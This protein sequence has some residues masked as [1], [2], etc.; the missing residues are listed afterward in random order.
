MALELASRAL[1]A[2]PMWGEDGSVTLAGY[3]IPSAVPNTLTLNFEGG[4]ND[5]ETFSF[6][7]L[8]TC[9]ER[10][11]TDFFNREFAGKIVIFGTLL[12]SEDRK[13]TSKRFATGLDGSRAP[14]CVLPPAPPT[15]GQFK[16]SSIAGVYIHATAV[17]NL[18]TRDAV[19]ELG[20]LPTT[21]VAIAFAA[22][23]ALAARMLTPGA[24][25]AVYLGMVAIWTCCATLVFTRSLA[26]P[27]SEPSLAGIASMAAIVAYRLVV[28]D[29]E[30]RLLRK[31]F[32][33][34]LAP[35]VIDKMLASNKLPV[36]GG[37]TRDVTVFFSDLAGFS[38]ISEKMTPAE[39]VTFMNEY[40]SAMTDIIESKGGYIDKY[41][42]DSIVAMFGAPAD[43]SD[44]A[45]NA[46]HAAL[47][48]RARL[49]QLNQSSAAFQG[50]KVAHRMGLNSGEALVGNIGSRRRFNY[51]VMSDAVN[52]ASRLE[53][54]N[55][56]YGT[57]IAASEMTVALTG[58]TFAWRELDAIRVQGRSAPVKIYELLAEA[59]QETPQQ[60][61]SAATYA[62]G[63][64]HWRIREF[65]A[66]ARCFERVA[67]VD[68]PSALFLSR[69]SAFANHPPGPDWVPVSTLDG[70]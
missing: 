19:V 35:Q 57:T 48:C 18:M 2:E 15:A 50:Y 58:S 12:D 60:A 13:L 34:Y 43:D 45:S 65:E 4:A 29:K 24:A 70:K 37:E 21:I 55:K 44:H 27:L 64:A 32:A 36:L 62:Q 7:D 8:R 25:A 59:G 22:L 63:L 33:L 38:S 40:L 28:T 51:S 46:A 66:A 41:I 30:E 20:R 31:S 17:H 52:V 23:A 1:N 61:A 68:K 67:D 42:G 14:R 9:V 11:N 3:R 26:L 56:Y 49:D 5:V 6:A 10:N 47:G 54:A 16:R 53:G 69:A 39:L